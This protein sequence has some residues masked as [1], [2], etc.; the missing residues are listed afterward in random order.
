MR[1]LLIMAALGAFGA[2]EAGAA[3]TVFGGKDARECY[4]SAKSGHADEA[5]IG[6]CTRA[7]DQPG[8]SESDR[9]GTFVNR[10]VMYL[11]RMQLRSA[12]ADLDVGVTLNP[13]AGE[14]WLD[15]GAVYIAQKQWRTAIAYIDH[16][17]QLG[18]SEPEKAYYDRAR[19]EEELDDVKGAYFDYQKALE[20][21]PDW[22]L[23]QSELKRFKVTQ[24]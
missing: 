15:R 18:V 8:L 13:A 6:L 5:S 19:A 9:G 2:T 7:L 4:L 11:R 3:V 24:K 14:G 23:A 20:I 17:I 22:D 16:A 21:R 12:Q 1:R 10:G